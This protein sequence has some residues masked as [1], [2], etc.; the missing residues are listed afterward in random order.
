MFGRLSV[1]VS[2]DWKWPEI[3]MDPSPLNWQQRRSGRT[4]REIE[5][6]TYIERERKKQNTA[7][8]HVRMMIWRRTIPKVR[9]TKTKWLTKV[10]VSGGWGVSGRGRVVERCCLRLSWAIQ[11]EQYL[12][13]WKVDCQTFGLVSEAPA[14][15][16]GRRIRSVLAHCSKLFRLRHSRMVCW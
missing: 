9:D 16:G 8:G 6:Y 2:F 4:P 10:S 13:I 15:A 3:W 7:R 5:I 11:W 14:K 1:L 12:Q